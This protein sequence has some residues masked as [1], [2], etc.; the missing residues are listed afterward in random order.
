MTLKVNGMTTQERRDQ[1][2]WL[3]DRLLGMMA[4][5]GSCGARAPVADIDALITAVRGEAY[6]AGVQQGRK[7]TG[8]N[9]GAEGHAR[10]TAASEAQ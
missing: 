6:A 4:C 8:G 2:I 7:E 10:A 3:V 1:L 9:Q 5:D